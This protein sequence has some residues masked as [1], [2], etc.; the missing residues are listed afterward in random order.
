LAANFFVDVTGQTETRVAT[1]QPA[2]LAAAPTSFSTT[3]KP[4]DREI[5]K[6]FAGYKNPCK[7][8]KIPCSLE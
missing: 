1:P 6:P 7:L 5:L 8:E 2:M 3:K 4:A